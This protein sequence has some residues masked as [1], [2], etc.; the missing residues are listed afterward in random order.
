MDRIRFLSPIEGDIL[1]S[2]ADGSVKNGVLLAPVRITADCAPCVNGVPARYSGDCYEA[3]VPLKCGPNEIRAVLP[4]CS[5]KSI[6]VWW[7]KGAEMKYR[8]TVDDCIHCFEDIHLNRNRYASIFDNPYLAIYKEA[9]DR[10][11]SR[12]HIN[13]FYESEDGSFNL[14]MMT[15]RFREEFRANAHWLTL[16]FH[17]RSEF[18]DAPYE[19]AAYEQVANDCAMCL[20]EIA[21]FAGPEVLRSSTTLHWGAANIDGVRALRDAG[22]KA[23]CGYLCFTKKGDPLVAY[24]LSRE[25]VAHAGKRE[26]WVDFDAGVVFM[27]LDFV[28]NDDKIP[29]ETVAPLLDELSTRPHEGRF[30]QMV[31]HEQ[32]FYPDYHHYEP[33]YADRI[34]NMARWMHEHGYESVSL[35]ELVE[36]K[37]G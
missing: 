3:M 8:F 22:Y 7:L 32:Y 2:R 11:G 28:L 18:P 29:A 23:L 34:L 20:R 37:I 1:I 10:Y 15:D 13:C 25:Q 26:G 4:D 36:E 35:T 27:K 12:V 16:S 6:R 19:N 33:D 31:I 21:R 9:H 24:H 17:S 30:I 14:S 5:E